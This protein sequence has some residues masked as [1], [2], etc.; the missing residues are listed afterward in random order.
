MKNSYFSK[1]RRVLLFTFNPHASDVGPGCHICCGQVTWLICIPRRRAP[2]LPAKCNQQVLVTIDVRRWRRGRRAQ[3]TTPR[4][5]LTYWLTWRSGCYKPSHSPVYRTM[6]PF[7]HVQ[8]EISFKRLRRHSYHS[9]P[10][11]VDGA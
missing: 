1:F 5:L 2:F 9:T 10:R 7:W 3:A 4:I 11:V 6:G 8:V